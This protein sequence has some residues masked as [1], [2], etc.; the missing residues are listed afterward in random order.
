MVVVACRFFVFAV[1]S[2]TAAFTFVFTF[3][4]AVMQLQDKPI[5]GF[6]FPD[7]LLFV[8]RIFFRTVRLFFSTLLWCSVDVSELVIL[9]CEAHR[10]SYDVRICL[11]VFFEYR[12]KSFSEKW[13]RSEAIFKCVRLFESSISRT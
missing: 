2:V 7:Q 11:C 6:V 10:R 1:I 4:F 5:V 8:F 9:C 13:P 12:F 3:C